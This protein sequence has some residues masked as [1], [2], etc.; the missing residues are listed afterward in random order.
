MEQEEETLYMFSPMLI[1]FGT[2][3]ERKSG[4]YLNPLQCN[5]VSKLPGEPAP[6]QFSLKITG[7]IAW[8]SIYSFVV[9]VTC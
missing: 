5:L 7:Q 9:E 2:P 1:H 6:M 8:L 3:C 4:K